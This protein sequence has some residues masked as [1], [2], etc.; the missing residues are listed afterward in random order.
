MFSPPGTVIK[1]AGTLAVSLPP[2]EKVVVRPVP[3]HMVVAPETKCAP[4]ALSV[5]AA[6]PAA[7]EFGVR[8]EREGAGALLVTLKVA[9]PEAAPPGFTTLTLGVVAEAMRVAETVAVS[10]ALL[11]N[12]VVS[13]VLPHLM[14]EPATKFDPFTLSVNAGPPAAVELGLSEEMAG[15]CT[16]TENV[17]EPDVAPPGLTT[18][19]L[20]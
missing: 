3:P 17:A 18:V 4:V 5:K 1:F 16:V 14:I 2:F 13:A 8:A 20:D 6:P 9:P 12:T 10:L 11:E 15:V 19:T 7:A